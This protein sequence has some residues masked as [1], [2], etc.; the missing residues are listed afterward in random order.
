MVVRVALFLSLV[1][2]LLG[3][4]MNSQTVA[5]GPP[6]CPQPTCAPAPAPY[7]P[8]Y[9]AP[10]VRRWPVRPFG[11]CGACVRV[12]ARTLGA[13]LNIPS[14]IMRGLLAPPRRRCGMPPPVFSCGP[15]P[16]PCAPVYQS[17]C[18]APPRRIS[19]CKPY[20]AARP[21]SGK[22]NFRYAARVTAPAPPYRP[23]AFR[24][25]YAPQVPGCVRLALGLM[26]APFQLVSGSLN[27]AGAPYADKSVAHKK[28]LFGRCW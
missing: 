12:C 23:A 17:A 18:P 1:L 8:C 25:D 9:P 26:E 14:I 5:G 20:A 10:C 19:K 3:T 6:A 22:V 16:R 4:S 13:C 11:L 2:L 27:S 21:S 24:P 15:A 28:P 7:Y